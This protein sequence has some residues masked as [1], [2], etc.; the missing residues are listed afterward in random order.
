MQKV[1]ELSHDIEIFATG[2]A[3]GYEENRG[4]LGEL[5]SFHDQSDTFGQTTWEKAEG[6]LSHVAW[7]LCLKE[8]DLS[9]R[10]VDALFS[11]DLQNQ[12]VASSSAHESEHI[13][14]VGLY[15]ACSTCTEGLLLGAVSLCANEQL[16]T[17]GVVTSSHNSAAERQFRTPL[18]YGAQRSPTAQWTATASGA[19]LLRRRISDRVD[20]RGKESDRELGQ[21][22]G[23]KSACPAGKT[24]RAVGGG[25][26]GETD[27]RAC[28]SEDGRTDA[29]RVGYAYIRR[30]MAG[31]LFDGGVSDA[32]NMGAAMA[33]AAA[34]SIYAFLSL[35][36]Q[37]ALDYDAIITGDLGEE[38]S[39]L[40]D[41]LLREKG[42]SVASVHQDCG[43]L[44][45]DR[46]RQDVHAGGS[47]CGCS[48]AVLSAYCLPKLKRR[49]WRR[50]LF[51]STGA[52]MSPSSLQ[53]GGTIIGVAP[54]IELCAGGER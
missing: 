6:E 45:Y 3:V 50:I 23:G 20:G 35:T 24:G 49:E 22:E 18:E 17:V 53:Q 39:A 40:L 19:F 37:S 54:V 43:L 14:Y 5:F 4:P 51:L 2:S 27:R 32:A 11:G 16:N 29:A 46:D 21:T 30:V 9:H 15:G 26:R 36:G 47:G 31:A 1:W 44:M 10:Q 7:N 48:A 28:M 41:I 8:A 42:I 34:E 25:M 12:C 33:P 38:G 52:M 13:P